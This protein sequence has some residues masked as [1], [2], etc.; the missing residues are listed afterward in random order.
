MCQK[1]PKLYTMSIYMILQLCIT[2]IV[3]VYA[4]VHHAVYN[5]SFI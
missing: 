5:G 3:V 1:W 4:N 2:E